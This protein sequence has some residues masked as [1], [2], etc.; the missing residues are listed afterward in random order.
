MDRQQT[1]GIGQLTIPFAFALLVWLLLPDVGLLARWLQ[2][3]PMQWLG[4][5]SYAIYLTHITVQ[6]VLDWPGRTLP[7]PWKHGVGIVFVVSVCLLS[8]LCYRTIEIPWRERGKRIARR[9]EAAGAGKSGAGSGTGGGS[10]GA[11]R[12]RPQPV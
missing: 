4:M 5:H 6:T 11:D 9:I 12:S 3:A 10:D 2:T 1:L 7:E 8:A